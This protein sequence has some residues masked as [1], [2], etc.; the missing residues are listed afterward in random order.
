[1]VCYRVG[2]RVRNIR[3]RAQKKTK[4]KIGG[5]K[6]ERKKKVIKQYVTKEETTTT[7]TRGD[8][9]IHNTHCRQQ[10]QKN[11]KDRPIKSKSKK[12]DRI[13]IKYQ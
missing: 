10:Y 3:A 9:Y 11:I 7:M 6:I 12:R 5:K 4:K 1:M 2:Y 8:E 13:H